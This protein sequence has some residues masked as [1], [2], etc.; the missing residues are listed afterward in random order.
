MVAMRHLHLSVWCREQGFSLIEMIVVLVIT[1]ILAGILAIV[2]RGPVQGYVATGQ[3]ADLTGIAETALQRMT[4]E[5]RLALPNSVRIVTAANI[6]TLEFL[7]TLDGGR[8]RARVTGGGAGNVLSFTTNSDS[9]D[10][11]GQLSNAGAIVTSASGNPNDCLD[12]VT[13]DCLVVYNTGQ[14]LTFAAAAA[15]GNSGNAYL[16]AAAAFDGN[17]ATIS[18]AAAT[19]LNFDNS[20]IVPWSF[21]FGSPNQRFHVVDT[22]VSFVC[23]TAAGEIN[24]HDGY[25]IAP[26]QLT[27]PGGA[28]TLLVDNITACDF[29]YDPGTASRGGLATLSITITHPVSNESVTLMQQAH[30]NNQP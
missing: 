16:G 12:G 20:T 30:V 23:N 29:D 26:A 7:R 14:P 1:G 4:R 13:A 22:P 11:L 28:T 8:Y 25:A 18:A 21:G 10:V 6:V 27:A 19:L 9:F 17:I 24:R 5:I 3:R 2:I 15:A